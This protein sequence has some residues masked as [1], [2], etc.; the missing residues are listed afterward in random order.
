MPPSKTRVV[1]FGSASLALPSLQR[2]AQTDEFELVAVVSQPD[3]P[4]GREGLLEPTP[5]ARAARQNNWPL[6][7]WPSLRSVEVTDHMKALRATVGVVVAYGKIIPPAL[8]ELFPKG[9]VNLHPSLLPK[10]RGPSPIQSAILAGDKETGISI[11]LLD[12]GMDTG[13]LLDQVRLPLSDDITA[14]QLT[15]IVA[16]QGSN[17]LLST[18]R[19][20]VA[21]EL[22]VQPQSSTGSSISAMLT[23]EDGQINWSKPAIE[24]DRQQRA[25]TPWPGIWTLWDGQRLKILTGHRSQEI[26]REP[27]GS[28]LKTAEGLHVQTGDGVYELLEVQLAGSTPSTAADFRRGHPEFI[29]SQL[30]SSETS[31]SR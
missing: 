25:L 18:L 3:K 8:L 6:F 29:G 23:R 15:S 7:Q 12:E 1:F 19:R 9:I 26:A 5:V 11:M 4:V 14:Q 31:S 2:L 30:S 20:Y 28:V 13:P 17:I 16:E 22:P 24:I 27:A 10:Y 21:G